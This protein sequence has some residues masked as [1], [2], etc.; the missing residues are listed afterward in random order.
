MYNIYITIPPFGFNNSK[1]QLLVV[2]F[3]P[4]RWGGLQYETDGDARRLA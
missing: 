4:G 3:I 1:D 2:Y